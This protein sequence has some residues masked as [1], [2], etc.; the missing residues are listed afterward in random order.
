MGRKSKPILAICAEFGDEFMVYNE[1]LLMCKSCK[2]LVP[3]K[4]RARIAEH[5][6]T[7]MHLEKATARN[8]SEED[9]L[10][11]HR[12]HDDPN[13][14]VGQEDPDEVSSSRCQWFFHCRFVLNHVLR[15]SFRPHN[16]SAH[17][18]SR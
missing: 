6:Q 18:L 3:V 16:P 15:A 14:A 13:A 5:L 17:F 1:F 12:A 8:T 11:P 10:S 9:Q 7:R 4:K 2:L